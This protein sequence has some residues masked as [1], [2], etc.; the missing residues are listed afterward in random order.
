[1]YSLPPYSFPI[2]SE[3]LDKLICFKSTQKCS[4]FFTIPFARRSLK[5]W[6]KIVEWMKVKVNYSY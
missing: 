5:T 1:M 6:V 2:S 3:R 4:V